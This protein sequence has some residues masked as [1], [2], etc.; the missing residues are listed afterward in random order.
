ARR[1]PGRTDARLARRGPGR[2]PHRRS[3]CPRGRGHRPVTGRLTST[4]HPQTGVEMT[5]TIAVVTAGMSSPSTTRLLADQLS[6]SAVEALDAQGI[7]A[8]VEVVELRPL[9]HGLADALLTG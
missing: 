6:R 2:S 7:D 9:A 4:H 3:T 5:R 1:R 8:V